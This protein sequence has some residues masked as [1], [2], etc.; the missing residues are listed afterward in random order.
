MFILHVFS[1]AN[2]KAAKETMSQERRAKRQRLGRCRSQSLLPSIPKC[3]TNQFHH[4]NTFGNI[5]TSGQAQEN[6][7]CC[8]ITPLL[9]HRVDV[10]L[11]H[12]LPQKI[13]SG[14]ARAPLCA[15]QPALPLL[16]LTSSPPLP[17]SGCTEGA[18]LKQER[19]TSCCCIFW[20][21]TIVTQEGSTMEL[22]FHTKELCDQLYVLTQEANTDS[23]TIL[24]FVKLC[25]C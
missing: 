8:S 13:I 5:G 15:G 18:S 24:D 21:I 25:L 4:L 6:S 20:F 22:S 11:T 2:E 1:S 19:S 16:S 10:L 3:T 17:L 9:Y 7:E 14:G 12:S 23:N